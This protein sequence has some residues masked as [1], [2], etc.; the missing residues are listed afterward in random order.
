M[1]KCVGVLEFNAII[2][3]DHCKE[4]LEQCLTED[5][6]QGIKDLQHAVLCAVIHQKDKHETRFSEDHCEKNLTFAPAAFN[7]VHFYNGKVRISLYE[8][9]EVLD[10]TSLPVLILKLGKDSLGPALPVDNLLRKVDVSDLEDIL[11]DV[12]VECTLGYTE[13][14]RMRDT[15]MIKGLTFYNQRLYQIGNSSEFRRSLANAG[16]S[17]LYRPVMR[18]VS[19]VGRVVGLDLG[20]VL[21]LFAAAGWWTAAAPSGKLCLPSGS[22]VF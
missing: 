16:M 10:R 11:V 3:K 12:I 1:F 7:S 4:S 6:C 19:F 18:C 5:F 14:R 8:R 9:F 15:D 13:F 2:G 21:L 22:T 17:I 20:T